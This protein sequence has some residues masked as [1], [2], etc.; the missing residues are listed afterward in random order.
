[1]G[2]RVIREADRPTTFSITDTKRYVPVVTLSTQDNAKLLQKLKLG[3]K[4]TVNRNKYESKI[5]TE[6]QNQYLDYL[7][8][9][10]FQGV[11]RLFLLSFQNEADRKGHTGYYLPTVEI[12]HYNVMI[13]GR[14]FFNQ[15]VR[16]DIKTYEN[17]KIATGHAD[18][19]NTF[20]LLDY[21]YFK[22]MLTA[23]DLSKQ[24][25]LDADPKQ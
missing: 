6:A 8:D 13:D 1:M 21:P 19:Y 4:R 18:D 3:S 5:S 7:I 23:I 10:R 17:I 25:A 20:C 16:N 22:K 11:N 12:K 2:E 14:Y 24:Q 15:P 9:P